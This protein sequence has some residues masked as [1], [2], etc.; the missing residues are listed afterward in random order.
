MLNNRQTSIL[1]ELI[2]ADSPITSEFLANIIQVTSRTIRNDIKEL[3]S[4]V[5]KY[6]STIKSTRGTGYELI[7]NDNQLFR[8]LLQEISQ[9]DISRSEEHP[10]LPEERVQYLIKRLLLEPNYVKLEDLADELFISKSTIQNDL[11][12]VKEVLN[13]YGIVLDK[14]PNY[15]IK[16]KG[17]EVKLRFCMSEYLFNR[18]KTE[19]DMINERVS[20]LPNSELLEIKR[21]ILEEIQEHDI[22]LSDVAFNNLIIHIAIACKRIRNQNYVSL[23]PD[24]LRDI[25]NQKEFEV[26]RKIVE[27]IEVQLDVVFPEAEVAYVAIHLLGTKMVAESGLNGIEVE[28]LINDDIH[29]LTK[30]ILLGIEE[31]LNL[32]IQNDKELNIALSLH[33]KPAINRYKY[34]MNLR[35]PMIEEIKSNYPLAFEAGIIAGMV[36][37]RKLGINIEESEIGY[38]ALHIGTAIERKKMIH[39][40]K[41]CM[42]VCA[43]GVGS[44]RLL[45]IKLQSKFRNQLE[46]LGTT[47]YYKLH[48]V[49]FHKLDFIVS[50]IPIST[51][52]PIPIIEVNTILGGN[53]FE[54]IEMA[55]REE[56]EYSLEYTK[57][58]LVFLQEKFETREEVIQFLCGKL[59]SKGLVDD[60]FFHLVM[61]REKIS[62]TAFGNLVAIPHPIMPKT[63]STFWTVCTLQKPIEW[64]GKRVQ[65]VCLLC[66]QKENE[67]DLKKMYDL[68]IK[69]IDNEK[70]VQ[71]LL[72]CTNYKQFINI[73]L[74]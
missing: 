58:D 42:I 32:G 6:G 44:A 56:K 35:N 68:L 23:Y 67:T 39:Q 27:K 74:Q 48:E 7:I 22:P 57:E 52:V 2:A 59:E 19:L 16:L 64:G 12:D 13:K 30:E 18:K 66:V 49:P 14:R 46:I 71:Q 1:R 60:T 25:I 53:D 17:E 36:L 29:D 38:I 55:L 47:E 65:F 50:T 8:K 11:R 31:K 62:S 10:D 43:S 72:K 20:I 54:K 34:G 63:D 24:D 69:V 51:P 5:E 21:V 3:E 15:G 37:K 70:I 45:T 9:D 26:A 61:E 33:L 4:L 41:K 73:F 40:P 28:Y